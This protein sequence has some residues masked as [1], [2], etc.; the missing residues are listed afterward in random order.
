MQE[1]GWILRNNAIWN[2]LNAVPGPEKDR[3]GYNHEDFF[4]FVHNPSRG[5][6]NYYYDLSHAEPG[7]GDV[8]SVKVARGEGGHTA[9]FPRK[10]IEPRIRTSSPAGGTVLDP[11][12]GTGRALQV[13]RE[14]GRQVIGFEKSPEFQSYAQAQLSDSCWPPSFSR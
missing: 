12:A 2:K 1:Q 3:L 4:H 14:C 10:L 7:R 13:A 5:R 9:T 8:V 6:A 11:F